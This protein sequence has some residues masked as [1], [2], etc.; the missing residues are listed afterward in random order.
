MEALRRKKSGRRVDHEK[1]S[2]AM[3]NNDSSLAVE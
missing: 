3:T 2:R 1:F